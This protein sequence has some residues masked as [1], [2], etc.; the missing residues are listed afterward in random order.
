MVVFYV[1]ARTY[2]CSLVR[3][4]YA[5]TCALRRLKSVCVCLRAR[6]RVCDN[7]C[8]CASMRVCM[9]VRECACACVY[10]CVGKCVYVRPH[11][12]CSDGNSYSLYTAW[13]CTR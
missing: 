12:S 7:M 1:C 3:R 6:E 13:A 9:S 10:V 11:A 5:R 2:V 4:S 8:I